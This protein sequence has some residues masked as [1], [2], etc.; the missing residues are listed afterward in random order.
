VGGGGWGE[1]GGTIQLNYRNVIVPP[2]LTMRQ[3]R[4]VFVY[5]SVLKKREGFTVGF[6]TECAVG[7]KKT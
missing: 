7:L 2:Q 4:C 1:E 3:T 5:T 6:K